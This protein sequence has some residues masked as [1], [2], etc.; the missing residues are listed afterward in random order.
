MDSSQTSCSKM[1]QALPRFA[2]VA[3][4]E[5][6]SDCVHG[7]PVFVIMSVVPSEICC[8]AVAPLGRTKKH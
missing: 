4:I 6:G 3:S 1:M 5:R 2:I 8:R 7:E